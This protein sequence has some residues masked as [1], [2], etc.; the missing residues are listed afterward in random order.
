MSVYVC[1]CIVLFSVCDAMHQLAQVINCNNTGCPPQQ[2]KPLPNYKT[3]VY[4]TH[5][6]TK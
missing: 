6:V 2:N 3:I 4:V 5:I 1:I